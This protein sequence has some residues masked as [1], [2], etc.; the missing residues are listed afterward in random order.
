MAD[1][2]YSF[3]GESAQLMWLNRLAGY[4][5]IL[6]KQRLSQ[7]LLSS[8]H[9]R[10]LLL[11]LVYIG[12]LDC[13]DISLLEDFA[14][15]STIFIKICICNYNRNSYTSFLKNVFVF[16]DFDE[17]AYYGLSRSWKQFK[18]LFDSASIEKL[19]DVFKI[20]GI[21]EDR[22]TLIDSI[23]KMMLEVPK[24]RKELILILNTVLEGN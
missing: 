10:K 2:F 5:K 20:L 13:R 11:S 7:V 19:Y 8:A 18:F 9:L 1:V 17:T 4:L 14:S 23:L 6:G 3:I 16:V 22:K 21:L 15:I 24:F 12:E